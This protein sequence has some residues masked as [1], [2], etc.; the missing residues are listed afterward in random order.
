MAGVLFEPLID[1]IAKE[2]QDG[3][4]SRIA[5]LTVFAVHKPRI[6]EKGLN[7]AGGVIG[8]YVAGSMGPPLKTINGVRRGTTNRGGNV[9]NL[10][11]TEQMKK[12]YSM[13][14]QGVVGYGFVN[15]FNFDKA[16]WNEERYNAA[17]FALSE[18]EEDLFIETLANLMIPE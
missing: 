8:T 2:L 18:E 13:T 3:K 16:T 17:I 12:D 1:S 7:A 11:F 6:F 15:Q 4:F 14:T 9:V 5:A 10:S